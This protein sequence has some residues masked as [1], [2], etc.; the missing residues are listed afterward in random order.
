MAH[1]SS[2]RSPRAVLINNRV[3]LIKG[4][5]RS[6]CGRCPSILVRTID[7]YYCNF[8]LCLEPVLYCPDYLSSIL[9][10]VPVKQIFQSIPLLSKFY[11]HF[12]N[13]VNQSKFIQNCLVKN[14]HN[15][16]ATEWWF[17]QYSSTNTHIPPINTPLSMSIC[18]QISWYI[19]PV[20]PQEADWPVY[21]QNLVHLASLNACNIFLIITNVIMLRT[22]TSS[23]SI[24]TQ[25][26]QKM[27]KFHG[28]CEVLVYFLHPKYFL[29]PK[30]QYEV[31]FLLCNLATCNYEYCNILMGLDVINKVTVVLKWATSM[32]RTDYES[33]IG[34]TCVWLF[35]NLSDHEGQYMILDASNVVETILY[36]IKKL[37]PP[38]NDSIWPLVQT[39]ATTLSNLMSGF[40]KIQHVQLALEIILYIIENISM[41]WSVE[42]LNGRATKFIVMEICRLLN[43]VT[44]FGIEYETCNK[45]IKSTKSLTHA[46]IVLD[47]MKVNGIIDYIKK[48][49]DLAKILIIRNPAV[50]T[51]GNISSLFIHLNEIISCIDKECKNVIDEVNSI[52]CVIVEIINTWIQDGFLN[53][54][55]NIFNDSKNGLN[56]SQHQT[57]INNLCDFIIAVFEIKTTDVGIIVTSEFDIITNLITLADQQEEQQIRQKAVRALWTGVKYSEYNCI[58]YFVNCGVIKAISRVDYGYNFALSW[59]LDVINMLSKILKMGDKYKISKN[60]FINAVE[61]QGG[62]KFMFEIINQISFA[63][64]HVLDI[65]QP[66]LEKYWG[67]E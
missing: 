23:G 29:Y 57:I 15:R 45:L 63:E 47:F 65:L 18:R 6:T 35:G 20:T 55:N 30:L 43:H 61:M 41:F 16:P 5:A 50:A 13:H 4:F 36:C 38:N 39:H 46:R 28:L 48:F 3:A 21:A 44:R 64:V 42:Y 59:A 53:T 25:V 33:Y 9:I 34:G 17:L 49:N 67:D 27:I 51:V 31:L 1:L 7:H 52:K 8:R 66:L 12:I 26:M 37:I 54:I 58:E 14:I 62:K 10:F 32:E 60:K 40:P 19:N 24:S 2:I 56:D 22:L 11:Y